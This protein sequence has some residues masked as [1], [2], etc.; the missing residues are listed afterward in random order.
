L[1]WCIFPLAEKIILAGDHLQLPPTVLSDKAMQ[2]GFNKS[3]LECSFGK[4]EDVYLLN[5]QYRMHSSIAQFS[6]AYFYEGL[7]QTP[8]NLMAIGEHIVFYDT[9]GTGYEEEQGPDGSS[10]SNK[11]EIELA[12]KVIELENLMHQK[13]AFI[14]PYS[15]QVTLAK[16]VL[17]KEM[18]SSTIDSFQGQEKETIIISLV[19][20][21]G[22]NT[23]GFLK[24]YR[25]MNVAMTRAKERLIIIGDSAT[26]AN[27]PYF[28]SL[29]NYL[30]E[31]GAYKTAWEIMY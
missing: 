4:F 27:D 9:A 20:S 23:I 5:T 7:L 31:I 21:N 28:D 24:D 6:N 13:T 25:R 26:L 2:L 8:E 11:G 3:I 10:L 30:E 19:R 18:R 15:G 17:P 22:E 12:L 1:A 29:M 14:S 16:E